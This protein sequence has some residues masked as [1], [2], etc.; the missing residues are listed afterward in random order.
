VP[1]EPTSDLGGFR[2]IDRATL[3]PGQTRQFPFRAGPP[4][5]QASFEPSVDFCADVMPIFLAKCGGSS[6]HGASPSAAASLVLQ[7]SEGVRVTA[8][9]RVAQGSNTG[10]R[11]RAPA[12]TPSVFGVDME[13]VRPGD[14]GSSWL[15]Y[16][17][18]LAPLP[19][20]DAGPKP[21]TVCT[22][23]AGAPPIPAPAAVFAPLAPA[24]MPASDAER[25]IL[26]DFIL[27][28]EMPYPSPPSAYVLPPPSAN[29]PHPTAYGLTPLDLQEREQ[30]R[31]WI[32]HGA[33]LRECGSCQ[34]R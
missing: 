22:P 13:L 21:A 1:T 30:L 19:P 14:P 28:Q 31:I 8:R 32:E 11:A 15:L 20:A 27:G 23:P 25:R 34:A 16:K 9:G 4:S 18:E 3:A 33:P 7:S 12:T 6:C 29:D 24:R 2:A 26:G 10:A 17:V 5:G